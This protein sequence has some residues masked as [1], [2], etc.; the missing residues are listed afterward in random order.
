LGLGLDLVSHWLDV[1][2]TY[3]YYFRLSLS[4]CHLLGYVAGKN[5]CEMT[6]YVLGGVLEMSHCY[7]AV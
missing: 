3:L 5:F 4:H 2:H 7:H 6:Y 1:M